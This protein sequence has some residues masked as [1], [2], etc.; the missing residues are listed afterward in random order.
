MH[1]W[2]FEKYDG[3][4]GFWNPIKKLFYSRQGRSFDMP[5]EIVDTMPADIFMDGEIWYFVNTPYSVI[6]CLLNP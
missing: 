1:R 2:M 6:T 3:V 4:R 5:K